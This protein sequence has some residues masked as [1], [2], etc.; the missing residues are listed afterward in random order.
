MIDVL[1]KS[2]KTLKMQ[3]TY[4]ICCGFRVREPRNDKIN[5][6]VTLVSL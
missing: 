3:I 2:L 4:L 5:E 1:K 6:L